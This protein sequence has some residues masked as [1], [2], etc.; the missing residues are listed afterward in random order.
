MRCYLAELGENFIELFVIHFVTKVLDV[1]IGEVLGLLSKLTLAVLT[2]DEPS[3]EHFLAVE[4]HTIYFC[5][6]V[7]SRLL[8]F[9]VHET[10]A[11][12]TACLILCYFAAQ[13]VSEGGECVI[14]GLV[15]DRLV[16]VLDKNVAHT[17][18]AERRVTLRPHD[19]NWS[20]SEHIKVHRVQGPLGCAK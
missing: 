10:V 19:A 13:N 15:V 20:A 2:R 17:R 1:D 5:D 3:N 18:T 7:D 16:Q 9:K 4:Q 14:H 11:F 8:C 6:G 12:R